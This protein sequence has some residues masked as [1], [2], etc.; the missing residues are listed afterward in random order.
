M[1]EMV[2][3]VTPVLRFCRRQVNR[4]FGV[5]TRINCLSPGMP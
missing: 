5:S 2:D 3:N 4:K 1:K